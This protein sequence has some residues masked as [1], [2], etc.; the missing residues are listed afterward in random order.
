MVG[1]GHRR[2]TLIPE[3]NANPCLSPDAGFA[4]A[5]DRAISFDQAVQQILH[6]ALAAQTLE[7]GKRR[8]RQRTPVRGIT[9]NHTRAI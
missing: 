1:G 5:L 4:A 6:D 7:S 2:P 9:L 3:I 8:L